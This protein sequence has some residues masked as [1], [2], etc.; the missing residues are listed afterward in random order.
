MKLLLLVFA[1]LVS[2]EE[3]VNIENILSQTFNNNFASLIA[4]RSDCAQLALKELIPQCINSGI[5]SITPTQQKQIA[6]KLSLCQFENSGVEY[7]YECKV[8]DIEKCILKLEMRPQYWTT[9][10][11]YYQD[12]KN[13]CHQL[14]AP[15]EKD[16]ILNIYENITR[17]YQDLYHDMMKSHQFSRTMQSD[18]ETKF[19]KLFNVVDDILTQYQ[20]ETSKF[21]NEFQ[22]DL[23]NTLIVLQDSYDG[24]HTNINHVNKHLQFFINQMMDVYD[25]TEAQQ[26]HVIDNNK[27]I[28]TQQST[29]MNSTNGM[30]R[31]IEMIMNHIEFELINLNQE[32]SSQTSIINQ[33]TNTMLFEFSK[34]ITLTSKDLIESF[35]IILNESLYNLDNK[36]NDTEQIINSINM[37]INHLANIVELLSNIGN[38]IIELAKFSYSIL[39]K[40]WFVIMGVISSVIILK[41]SFK[42]I[43]KIWSIF[44]GVSIIPVKILQSDTAIIISSVGLGVGMGFFV[45]H[46]ISN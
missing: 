5:E 30:S 35:E 15:F 20:S 46:L 4:W 17:I 1:L 44:T 8:N 45:I 40:H 13:I 6:I 39:F 24:I 43:V 9:Y 2:C 23:N 38:K 37:K 31:D 21:Q 36:L 27:Q 14:S 3:I 29:I 22:H 26:R 42:L 34:S 12:V 16:Q 41:Y 18:I 25:M 28:L 19:E 7:P 32:L 33:Q 11:G 10:S